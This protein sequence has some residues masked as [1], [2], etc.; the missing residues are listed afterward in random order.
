MLCP[1]ISDINK[2]NCYQYLFQI[3]FSLSEI[4]CVMCCSEPGSPRLAIHAPRLP[5]G[6]SPIKLQFNCD[7]DMEDWLAHLTSGEFKKKL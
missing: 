1:N 4:T 6:S 3:Q 7:S 5:Q 2:K